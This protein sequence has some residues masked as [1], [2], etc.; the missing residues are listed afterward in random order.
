VPQ[1]AFAEK[2]GWTTTRLRIRQ[3]NALLH[4]AQQYWNAVW[5]LFHPD[6]Y[7]IFFK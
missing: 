4:Q 2:I 3:I 5:L 7:G 1:A 6:L